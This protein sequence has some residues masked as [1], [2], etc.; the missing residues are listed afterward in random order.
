M[1]ASLLAAMTCL[2][3]PVSDPLEAPAVM[4]EGSAPIA[5]G[6]HVTPTSFRSRNFSSAEQMLVF[7][8][9]GVPSPIVVKLPVGGI[10]EYQFS[11]EAL[12]GVSLEIVEVHNNVLTTGGVHA[13]QL[14][15]NASCMTLWQVPAAPGFATWQQ[16]GCEVSRL[17]SAGT[18]LPQGSTSNDPNTDNAVVGPPVTVPRVI[19]GPGTQQ[20]GYTPM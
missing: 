13:L 12:A 15:A 1:L 8:S 18:L 17:P 10:V 5:V 11:P 20:E 2:T 4:P 7:V 6:T 14:P 19:I 9:Q 16:I 3:F